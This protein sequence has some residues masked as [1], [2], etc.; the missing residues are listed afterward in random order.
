MKAGC[1]TGDKRPVSLE[2]SWKGCMQAEAGERERR[3]TD[4]HVST[5]PLPVANVE[6]ERRRLA[7]W[8]GMKKSLSL[9]IIFTNVFGGRSRLKRRAEGSVA[10]V[11]S[12]GMKDAFPLRTFGM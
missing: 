3:V 4:G 8:G 9:I 7:N 10:G 5:H 2:A 12:S 11:P 1:D 6:R